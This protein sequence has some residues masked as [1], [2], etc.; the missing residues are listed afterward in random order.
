[1][2]AYGYYYYIKTYFAQILCKVTILRLKYYVR[3]NLVTQ[4]LCKVAILIKCPLN[5]CFI[6]HDPLFKGIMFSRYDPLFREIY[7]LFSEFHPLFRELYP[8]FSSKST[9]SLAV[10][11]GESVHKTTTNFNF[12][13]ITMIP[14]SICETL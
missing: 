7:P 1:M 5:R 10:N 6:A 3:L 13:F 11:T 9:L 2:C 8:L 4:I 14:V 12:P